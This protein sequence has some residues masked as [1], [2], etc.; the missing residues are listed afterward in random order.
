MK[1]LTLMIIKYE[2]GELSEDDTVDLFASLIESGMV[3]KLQGHYGRTA[4][5]LIDDGWIDGC[6]KVLRRP[7]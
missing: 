7:A 2:E 6:G 4:K 3:W 1:D 5:D